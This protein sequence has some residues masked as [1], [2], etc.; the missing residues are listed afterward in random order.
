MGADYIWFDVDGAG[1]IIPDYELQKMCDEMENVFQEHGVLVEAANYV[2][3]HDMIVVYRKMTLPVVV[4]HCTHGVNRTGFV[5]VHL[6][7]Y[8]SDG[9][10]LSKI[11]SLI[12]WIDGFIKSDFWQG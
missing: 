3:L 2:M 6:L 8:F 5:F 1:K 7:R 10:T 9:E 11:D 4:L 12:S